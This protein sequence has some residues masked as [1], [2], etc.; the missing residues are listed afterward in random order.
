MAKIEA[1]GAPVLVIAEGLLMYLS[2]QTSKRCFL[3]LRDRFGDV[4]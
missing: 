1:G 2:E 4:T 3:G